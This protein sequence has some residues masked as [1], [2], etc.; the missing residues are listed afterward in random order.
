MR[1]PSY[2][3]LI[4]IP[5]VA[6][7]VL[8]F[9]V[10][11]FVS[12]PSTLGWVGFAVVAVVSVSLGV[13]AA[14]LF[15]RSR[16]NARRE[17]PRIGDP[18]RLLVV[19]DAGCREAALCDAVFDRALA[20]DAEVFVVAPVVASPL[21]VLAEAESGERSEAAARLREALSALALHGIHARGIVGTD[22][23]V[24][25]VGDALA[26]FPATEILV[27][28]DDRSH[29]RWLER[30]LERTVRDAYGVHVSTVISAEPEAART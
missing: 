24:L 1:D 26:E 14:V 21:H 30:D 18:F 7:I 28:A 5:I 25:A 13:V 4:F 29:R 8:L 10:G 6:F 12:H 19:A 9:G 15:P 11:V 27:V 22:D 16:I 20:C 17:R 3:L 23:P 2:R